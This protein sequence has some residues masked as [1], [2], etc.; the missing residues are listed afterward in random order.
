MQLITCTLS[1]TMGTS[2]G[3]G[4]KALWCPPERTAGKRAGRRLRARP[5]LSAFCLGRAGAI[6]DDVDGKHA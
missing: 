6:A 1:S 2:P 4:A 3:M 5:I